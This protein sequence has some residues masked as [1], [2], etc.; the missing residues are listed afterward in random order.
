MKKTIVA[1]LL[2]LSV[3]LTIVGSINTAN[4]YC[5]RGYYGRIHCNGYGP[6]YGRGYWGGPRYYYHHCRT[7]VGPYGYWHRRCW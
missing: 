3:A 2:G 5:W 7:W 4:A 1:I 6:G